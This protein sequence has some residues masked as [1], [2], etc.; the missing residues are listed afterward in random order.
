M[1]AIVVT[2]LAATSAR[3][4]PAIELG[5]SIDLHIDSGWVRALG[6]S[7]GA[8]YVELL[9]LPEAGWVRLR[10]DGT[11][12]R[13]LPG[14]GR[15]TELR[16]T[17]LHD[18]AVQRLNAD[19]LSRWGSTSAY[20]N[21]GQVLVELVAEPGSPPSRL[22]IAGAWV[23]IAD[24]G[25]ATIC[26]EE[27][28]RQPCS[29]ARIGRLLPVGCT[30]WIIDDANHCF[31][32]AGHCTLYQNSVVE[33][34]VP[35]SNDDGMIQHPSPQHQYPVDPASVQSSNT[36]I[37]DDWA[38]F[39][40]FPNVD[41][42]ATAYEAQGAYFELADAPMAQGDLVR[43]AGYGDDDSP[44]EWAHTL[45][46]HE[47]PF[48]LGNGTAL[49][50]QVDTRTGSSGSPVIELATGNAIGIH[51]N[52]GCSV[53]GGS[54]R[55]TALS[56]PLLQ[57]ALANPLGVCGWLPD[58]SADITADGLVDVDDLLA[59]LLSWGMCREECPGD[60]TA[61]GVVGVDDLL[62]LVTAWGACPQ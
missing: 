20:F 37:G 62:T 45:Q 42:G 43:I 26:G 36:G 23:G 41:T 9:D 49:D 19:G 38:Y 18:G 56:N 4:Q 35:F 14:R 46:A 52:G 15:R 59:L 60:L 16:L 54:N 31:L 55:G 7:R 57:A 32:G 28:D 61:D 21:G 11:E 3:A 40:C 34:N 48:I 6:E 50:Y 33:F 5:A 1:V 51:T 58:C 44:P 39:G 10:F 47:G 2:L 25:V 53:S 29:D 30:A 22:R 8:A 24:G 13:D 17:S 12:L 27:D